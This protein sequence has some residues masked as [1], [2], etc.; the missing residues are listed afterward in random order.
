MALGLGVVLRSGLVSDD[1]AAIL[2]KHILQ[3][4]SEGKISDNLNLNLNIYILLNYIYIYNIYI[5][6]I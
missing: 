1:M 3:Y 4:Q 5:L 6:Y 2:E